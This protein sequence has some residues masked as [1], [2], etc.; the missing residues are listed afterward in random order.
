MRR[1]FTLIEMVVA[2]A[3]L[4]MIL[5]FAGIIFR[6]SIESQ[7]MALANTEV[8]QKYRAITA[9]LDADLR[10]LCR[11][12]E[13][14]IIWSALR[15]SDFSGS[16][17][18]DPA[19]FERFDR[20]MFFTTGDFET[21]GTVPARRG[22]TARVCYILARAPAVSATDPN[23]HPWTQP[24]S[25][26]ILARTQHILV[27]WRDPNKPLDARP[28][29]NTNGFTDAQWLAWNSEQEIDRISLAEWKQ[30]PL[31][32]KIN[33][34]SIIGDA[35]VEATTGAGTT[36]SATSEQARGVLIDRA[37]PASFSALLCE[38]VGQFAVQG[39]NDE[40]QRWM[41]E[42]NPDGDNELKDDSDFILKNTPTGW[43]IDAGN[44]P[45]V[46]YPQGGLKMGGGITYEGPIDEAHFHLI[47]GLGRALKFTFTL[48][49][50]RGLLRNG[51]VFTHIVYLDI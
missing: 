18:N 4:A 6:V 36:R 16:N 1:A 12:G 20:I 32:E 34:L 8:M 51:R 44:D 40:R 41:P 10:G 48:Y 23:N 33:I 49:D 22:N 19:A 5:V 26:R 24:P 45:G 27:P 13:L 38:G 11:D 30:M 47:P 42:V 28:R 17:R 35:R 14:F 39:W 7:R 46:W 43:D 3:I 15:K 37:R 25:R 21:Y 50:S 9:Q 29:L 31:A 2:L